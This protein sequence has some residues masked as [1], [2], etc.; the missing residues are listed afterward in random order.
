MMD[1]RSKV[2]HLLDSIHTKSLDAA[3]AAIF[4]DA[5]IRNDYDYD[6][7]VDLLQTFVTQASSGQTDTSNVASMGQHSG[8]GRGGD[9]VARGHGCGCRGGARRFEGRG[10]SLAGGTSPSVTDITPHR[11]S[12]HLVLNSVNKCSSSA[13]NETTDVMLRQ[14]QQMMPQ[15]SLH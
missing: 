6:S 2:R 5:T 9:P 12:K 15:Q 3:K 10:E 13:N 14:P 4:A 8:R 11:S 1:E 7:A